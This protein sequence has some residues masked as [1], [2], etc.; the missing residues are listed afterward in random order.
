MSA[1]IVGIIVLLVFLV[2][3]A[4]QNAQPLTLK[5][6]LWE[7]TTSAVLSILVSFVIGFLVGCL[8]L[9]VGPK[10]KTQSASSPPS[11]SARPG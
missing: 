10:K 1:K 9:W 11:H 3:F 6:L 5:F 8:I 7:G 2:V 4:I